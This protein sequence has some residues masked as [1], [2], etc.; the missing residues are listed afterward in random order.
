MLMRGASVTLTDTLHL[1][2]TAGW[3]LVTMLAMGFAGAAL[4]KRFLYYTI[5]TIAIMLL[6]GALTGTQGGRIQS[7]LST[8]WAGIT[9]Q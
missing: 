1:V 5:A 7:S 2:W 9:E 4:G 3:L 6:F 8:P